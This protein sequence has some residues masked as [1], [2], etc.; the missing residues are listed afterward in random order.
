MNKNLR[1]WLVFFQ[2]KKTIFAPFKIG[3]IYSPNSTK[4]K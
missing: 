1:F 3:D 2:Y 4:K